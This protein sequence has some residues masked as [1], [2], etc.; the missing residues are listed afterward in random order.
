M[1]ERIDD[2][3]LALEIIGRRFVDL[4]RRVREIEAEHAEATAERDRTLARLGW[5]EERASAPTTRSL[6]A[7]N[8]LRAQEEARRGDR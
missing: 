8:K 4:D 7:L 2:I 1:S 5:W 3:E 6:T